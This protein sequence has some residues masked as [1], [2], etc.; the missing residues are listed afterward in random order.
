MEIQSIRPYGSNTNFNGIERMA[1]KHVA[2]V[3]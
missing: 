2:N 3:A 1:S